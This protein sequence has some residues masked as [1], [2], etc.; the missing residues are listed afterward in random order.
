MELHIHN[1]DTTLAPEGKTVASVNIYTKNSGYWIELRE[2]N[3]ESYNRIKKEFAQKVIDIL[4]KKISGIKEN[5]EQ[6]DVATPATFKRFTNNWN[7]SIQGWLPGK[8]MIAPTPVPIQLPG[9]KN[10]YFVGHWTIPG[11]GLPVAI[12]SAR[13]VAMMICHDTQRDFTIR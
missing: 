1:Y 4:E 11:G 12:K 3:L 7:G 10:L 6:V 13:D 2:T 9:L 5:I 8:N